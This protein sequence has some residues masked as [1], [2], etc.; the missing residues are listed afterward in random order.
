MLQSKRLQKVRHNLATE[1]QNLK[2]MPKK[3]VVVLMAGINKTALLILPEH[4]H[5]GKSAL[6]GSQLALPRMTCNSAL[7]HVSTSKLVQPL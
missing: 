1:E 7:L 4:I 6:S 2:G 3:K 5:L